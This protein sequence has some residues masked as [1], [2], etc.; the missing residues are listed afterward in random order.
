MRT[1]KYKNKN[2]SNG[3]IDVIADN[4]WK[5]RAILKGTLKE[6]PIPT[7]SKNWELIKN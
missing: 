7:N 3:V 6:A 4:P 5:A 2:D 1:F